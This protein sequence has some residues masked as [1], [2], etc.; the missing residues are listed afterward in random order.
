M[1]KEQYFAVAAR[2]TTPQTIYKKQ[3]L[4]R[5]D[6]VD[7]TDFDVVAWLWV[8]MYFM[9]R[10]EIARAILVG[11]GREVD[12]PDKI[13]ETHI[14]P[15]V[16]DDTFY[17]DVV[18]VPANVQGEALIE[19]ALRA[20]NNYKG[21]APRA[22][23]TNAVMID[24]LL[25]KD[26]LGRRYHN[27]KAELASALGVSEIVEVPVL[28]GVK[29]DGGDVMM[30]IVNIYDYKVGSTRGGELT[31]FEDFDIDFNQHKYLIEARMAGALVDHKTAQVIVRG[32][33]TLVTPTVPTFNASTGVVT[34]PSVTGVT[35]KNQQTAATLTAGPQTAIDP[36]ASISVV[37][38]PNTGYYFPHNFDNDWTFVRDEA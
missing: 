23:M 38:T 37:A 30:V 16:H 29:R 36:G 27:N 13:N 1:K 20:R 24:M 17:T 26:N 35:Y 6:I 22:Y 14:R 28:E 4:D 7:I 21:Q 19:A 8:E 31:K 3:K 11:D 25:S 9:I 15:I 2:T 34:I 18:V 12:D 10:E 33:G 5:D 32:A